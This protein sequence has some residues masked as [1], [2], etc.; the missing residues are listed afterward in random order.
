MS[1][2]EQVLPA[3]V[4]LLSTELAA[5]DALLDDD[6]FQTPFV[7]RFACCLDWTR[8]DDCAF[9]LELP[10][11]EACMHLRVA[12]RVTTVELIGGPTPTAQIHDDE[13]RPF[14]FP[15]LAA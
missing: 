6:R 12:G 13:V 9:R 8:W 4:R 5:I 15:V 2:W 14:S 11:S 1:L 7:R 10:C 3:E